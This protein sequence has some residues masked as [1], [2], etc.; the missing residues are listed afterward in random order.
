M[1]V[2]VGSFFYERNW[3]YSGVLVAIAE[4]EDAFRLK[5]EAAFTPF[6]CKGLQIDQYIGRL[7]SSVTALYVPDVV[8]MAL[9]KKPTDFSWHSLLYVR[10]PDGI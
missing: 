8:H 5:C 10:E 1:A 3:Q 9:D 2:Y 7:S 6:Y 4:N